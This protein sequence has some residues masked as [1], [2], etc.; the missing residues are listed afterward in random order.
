MKTAYFSLGCFWSPQLEFEKIKGVTKAEVGYCGGD[1]PNTNYEKVCSGT[2]NHAE[3]VK[4]EF[5]D[6]V[7]SYDEL[8]RF[9]FKIHDPTQLNR[10]GPDVGSQY[11][12]EIFYKDGNQKKIAEKIKSEFNNKLKGKIVTN[13]SKEKLYQP[14]EKYHQYYLKRKNIL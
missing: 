4:V 6:K 2:T 12:S 13:I 9:F 5:D 8:V 11:R 1:D 10:Q 14:A 7:V 3:T